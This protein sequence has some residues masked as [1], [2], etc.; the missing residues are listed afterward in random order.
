ML[1]NPTGGPEAAIDAERADA[2]PR[3]VVASARV[4]RAC[5]MAIV[6]L[7]ILVLVGWGLDIPTLKSTSPGLATMKANTAALFIALGAALW[8]APRNRLARTRR[9]LA[10]FVAVVAALTLAQYVFRVDFGID[11]LLTQDRMSAVAPGRMAPATS[12]CFLLLAIAL[13]LIDRRTPRA[14]EVAAGLAAVIA[15]LS[16]SGYVFGVSSLYHIGPY[17]SIALH[18]TIAFLAAYVAFMFAR[19]EEGLSALLVSDT[20]AGTILRPLLPAIILAPLGLGW[21]QQRGRATGVYDETFGTAM[22][23][24]I[25]VGFLSVVT[26]VVTGSLRTSE[27]A[28]RSADRALRRS[29]ARHS[30]ILRSSPDAIVTVDEADAIVDVNPAAER[31]FGS[32]RDVIR[33]RRLHDLL[34]GA[35]SVMVRGFRADAA[36][37]ARPSTPSHGPHGLSM[38]RADG[39]ELSIEVTIGRVDGTVPLLSTVFVRDVSERQRSAEQFRH[40]IEA[41][42]TGM[43]MVDRCGKI[44]LVN[45][46]TER[47]FGF[48]RDELLGRPVEMLIPERLR[49]PHPAFRETFH[50][51]PGSRT[52]GA[53]RDL[54]GL[55]KDGTE[56]PIEIGLNPLQTP[57]G[58]F[59]LSSVVDIRARRRAEQER[60]DLMERLR[61]ANTDLEARV[62]SRTRQLQSAL[63]E[64]DVLLQEVHHRVKNNLQVISSLINMQLRQLRS[65][66]GREALEECR[67][68]VSTIALIHEKLYQSGD[69]ARITMSDYIRSLAADVFTAFTEA[70]GRIALRV[71]VEAVD[72]TVD[73]AI[74]CG[75]ILNELLTNAFKHAFPGERPGVVSVALGR[76][77][78]HRL[79]LVVADDGVGM[80]ADPAVGRRASL[81]MH[82]VSTLVE[83]LDGRLEVTRHDGTTFRIEFPDADAPRAPA[84]SQHSAE[85]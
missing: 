14:S 36:A 6:G 63:K 1:P 55:R 7:G 85:G 57:E 72:L 34:P 20:A 23:A 51:E 66:A 16:F 54:Y 41:A 84:A 64:R 49:G 70:P 60:E 74:P 46:Q 28:R 12:V 62:E 76:A 83:Q 81:G 47:L 48:S 75:L 32:P 8:C 30:A 52:M 2:I 19:P 10:M 43:I 59:V 25:D 38:V 44:V 80:P 5:S 69:Y 29:E 42:P 50:R 79:R 45:T 22:A 26:L 27:L 4:S 24:A 13:L 53:G 33:T 18:T 68:R 78:D 21:L 31:L 15:F 39:T 40:A 82:L 35:P 67:G 37:D 73:R 11:Q 65:D 17:A 9:A 58:D 61:G 71:N 56:V 77:A 3:L